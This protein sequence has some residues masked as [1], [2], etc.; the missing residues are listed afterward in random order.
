MRTGSSYNLGKVTG[1]QC[2]IKDLHITG[3]RL[4]NN[5]KL[6]VGFRVSGNLIGLANLTVQSNS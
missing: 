4:N 1:S 6:L 3:S 2:S 5:S